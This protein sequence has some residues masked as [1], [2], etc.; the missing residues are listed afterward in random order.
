[1]LL[2]QNGYTPLHIAA[3]KNETEIAQLLLDE[4]A[5]AGALSKVCYAPKG[6]PTR[7]IIV[8]RQCR[9]DVVGRYFAVIFVADNDGQCGA[10]V[11]NRLMRRDGWTGRDATSAVVGRLT[12][13]DAMR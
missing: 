12:Q 6:R 2:L 3:R 7:P 5:N 8:G 11:T 1:M 9:A 4:N 10:A 13:G